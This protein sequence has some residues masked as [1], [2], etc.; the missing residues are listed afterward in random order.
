MKKRL[1]SIGMLA[2][3]A[4]AAVA[5]TQY[6]AARFS[7]SELNGTAR[8]VGMG[9]A[10]SALGADISVIGTNPAGI[11]LFRSHDLSLS[12]G[13]N[14]NVTNSNL[15]G[16]EV[17]DERTRAS[18]DQLGFVYSTKIGNKTDL[19]YFN[20][21][22][23]YHKMANFNRQFSSRGNL[24]GSSLS[25]Q[26]QDM[27]LGTGA[28]QN[29]ASY[30]ALLDAENPYTSSAYYGTPF[31]GS[32][33]VRTGLVDDVTGNDGSFGM[34]GWNGASG[35]YYSRE[36]GGINA[37]DF[38]LSFNVQDRFYFGATLGVYDVN[39]SRYSSYYETVLDDKGND[40]GSFQLNNW[41]TTDGAGLDLK[42]GVIV[43]PMEYSPFRIGFAVHT[44]IWYSLNDRYTATLG[45]DILAF[46]EKYTENLSDYYAP[47]AS[48]LL[49]YQLATPWK[50]NVSMGT[51]FSNVL[52]VDAEYEFANYAKARYKDAGGYD[53]AAANGAVDKYLKNVHT[54][55]IGMEA[56]FTPQFSFRAGYNYVTSPIADNSAR[57][58]PNLSTNKADYIWFDETR[59]DP[60][61]HN[62]KARNTLTLGLGYR[63]K[64]MYADVA[65]KYD[66]Y[67][68]DFYMFDDYRFSNDG[69]S[70][71]SRNSAAAVN[72]DRHQLLL[73]LG[74]KF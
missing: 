21:G 57:Y 9:G 3:A 18:F 71:V 54:F 4:V 39:Y 44:P 37:Y 49:E 24:N 61:Y 19:R 23:N 68:S 40:N 38:N 13:F 62:L 63:G 59:T 74:V 2:M 35:D 11:G 46:P 16:T 15:G 55:R 48:Y 26:M 17:K 6:D 56:K 50:F 14:K 36:E 28:Y 51:T 47:D 20:I 12:F 41:F 7:G 58:V 73:T 22:F 65:Y 67:K 5:Q 69:N 31:L 60:E 1:F 27:M 72:H 30:D 64:F 43:R 53:L 34:M 45:T 8:F 32:M 52:A 29:Q 42:L 10:M 25:W 66:F 70:I 33:G